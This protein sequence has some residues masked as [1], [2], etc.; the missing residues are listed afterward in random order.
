MYF[1]IL[2]TSV[3]TG[4]SVCSSLLDVGGVIINNLCVNFVKYCRKV[5]KMTK[6]KKYLKL[7]KRRG[8]VENTEIILKKQNSVS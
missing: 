8:L 4:F 3:S 5:T 6:Q 1:H 2:T 7:T